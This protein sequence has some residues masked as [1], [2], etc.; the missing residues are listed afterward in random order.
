M[1]QGSPLFA[2]LHQLSLHQL[3]VSPVSC[4]SAGAPNAR[5]QMKFIQM[6]VLPCWNHNF[7]GMLLFTWEHHTV[8]MTDPSSLCWGKGSTLGGKGGGSDS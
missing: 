2:N 5:L 6:H 1:R 8:F 4:D 3:L 7:Q